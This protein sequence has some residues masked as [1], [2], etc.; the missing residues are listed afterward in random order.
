VRECPPAFVQIL[1][2]LG[3]DERGA[4]RSHEQRNTAQRG[5]G[6]SK[7]GIGGRR[8]FGGGLR[9]DWDRIDQYADGPEIRNN[10]EAGTK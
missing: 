5:H 1:A 4:H 8:L 3:A 6:L 7:A 2:P 10:S 9:G